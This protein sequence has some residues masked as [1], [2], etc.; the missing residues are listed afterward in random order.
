MRFSECR[1][2]FRIYAALGLAMLCL[3]LQIQSGSD[4]C[5]TGN[6]PSGYDLARR[7]QTGGD[8]ANLAGGQAGGAGGSAGR[9][10]FAA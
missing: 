3:F 9:G 7:N 4:D 8:S 1:H 2:S 6:N 5:G 10:T